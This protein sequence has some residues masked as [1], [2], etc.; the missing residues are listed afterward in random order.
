M[1]PA[2]PTVG[3]R[4]TRESE[5]SELLILEFEGFGAK[6][7]DKV[8][9]LLGINQDTGEGD[10]PAGLHTHMAGPTEGGGWIVVEVWE[11]QADQDAFMK[12]T[13]RSSA[14]AGGRDRAAETCGV[15]QAPRAP[16]AEEALHEG[17]VTASDHR[18]PAPRP[19][20]S[21]SKRPDAT[22]TPCVARVRAST[23]TS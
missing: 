13:S 11:T 2:S 22:L 16:H 21:V 19:E 3:L 7:Y 23:S 5:M 6:D 12:Y 20:Q 1:I 18:R 4:D 8:N 9:D 14:A 17:E 15:E 10:W